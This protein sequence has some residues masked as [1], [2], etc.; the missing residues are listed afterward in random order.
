MRR[1]LLSAVLAGG[2]AMAACGGGGGGGGESPAANC[3]PSGPNVAVVAEGFAFDETCYAAPADTQFQVDLDSRDS[4]AHNFAIYT[5][6][7]ATKALFVSPNV[8]AA[9][10]TFSV[11]PIA[12]GTY[13][14]RCDIHPTT[15]Y[16]A[17]VV[18]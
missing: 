16:G 4:T 8:T 10:Q 18:K 2:L 15:M 12:A 9:R 5:D 6:G 17:F 3:S 11:K 7:S 14:F 1:M 13:F